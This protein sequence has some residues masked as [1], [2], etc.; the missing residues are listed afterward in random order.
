LKDVF[1]QSKAD[2]TVCPTLAPRFSFFLSVATRH[3]EL[4]RKPSTSIQL[5]DGFLSRPLPE[6]STSWKLVG[7]CAARFTFFHGA[8]NGMKAPPKIN[9]SRHFPVF[10]F[11]VALSADMKMED[12]KIGAAI[13]CLFSGPAI[14]LG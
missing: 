14:E 10:H 11:P 3:D 12:R 6:A 13:Y 5:V 1:E 4:H 7:H 8:A 2:W 9:T